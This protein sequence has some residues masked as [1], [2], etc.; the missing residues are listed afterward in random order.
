MFGRGI[1]RRGLSMQRRERLPPEIAQ[2]RQSRLAF[3]SAQYWL[4]VQAESHLQGRLRASSG[5]SGPLSG[6][7]WTGANDG[8]DCAAMLVGRVDRDSIDGPEHSM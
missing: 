5:H 2:A 3:L 1:R 4:E 8:A 6:P 7:F